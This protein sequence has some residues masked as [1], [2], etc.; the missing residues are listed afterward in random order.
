MPDASYESNYTKRTSL[1]SFKAEERFRL[2]FECANEGRGM[3][4]LNGNIFEANKALADLFG[5]TEKKLRKMNLVDL[6]APEDRPRAIDEL[7]YEI[8]GAR[9]KTV[10]EGRYLNSLGGFLFAEVTRG[11]VRSRTG[12]PVYF[13]FSVRDITEIR[14]LQARLEEQA[15]TDSLTGATCRSRFE[16]RAQSEILRSDRFGEELSLVII[17]LDRFKSVNDS[18]GH[19]AGDR[20]LRG[21]CD[22]ARGRLRSMDILGRWGGEEFVALLPGTGLGGAY[23]VADR[24]RRELEVFRFDDGLQVTASMGV[25]SHRSEE[26]LTSLIARADACLYSAKNSGRN[27]VIIDAEDAKDEA[28]LKNTNG[29]LITLHWR[30]SYRC[31]Q[32][33]IDAEHEHLFR[34][35][36]QIIGA[37]AEG[38]GGAGLLPLVQKLISHI[39]T[40]LDHETEILKAVGFPESRDHEDNHC[41]LANRA[42]QMASLYERG[43]G[44]EVDL[45]QFL[46]YDIVSTHFLGEDRKFFPWFQSERR[47]LPAQC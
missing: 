29:R 15:S 22:I 23:A 46:I 38:V 3:A 11:L 26:D 43:K 6:W 17:D 45:L 37:M 20:V 18:F 34:L 27:R 25:A 5:F 33:I 13:A 12:K 24:L 47:E 19:G 10:F 35:G 28:G 1:A 8:T 2:A 40:H 44:S 4:D 41:K 9:F 36:N 42:A 16:E 14:L 21:F 32:P 7:K 30:P 31:G 39:S